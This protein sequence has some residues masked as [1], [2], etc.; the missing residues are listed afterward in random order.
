MQAIVRVGRGLAIALVLLTAACGFPRPDHLAIVG[1][2]V[3]GLW[4][5]ADGV[6]LRL[7]ANSQDGLV[8]VAADG[9]FRF[10]EPVVEGTRM[11]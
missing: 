10:A 8:T 1:A 4:N 9:A 2:Q 5:G 7:E 11:S 3:R 6:A